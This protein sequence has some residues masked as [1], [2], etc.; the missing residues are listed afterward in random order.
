MKIRGFVVRL[1]PS[2]LE[3]LFAENILEVSIGRKFGALKEVKRCVSPSAGEE[4]SKGTWYY[5]T[6]Y[7]TMIPFRRF[8][9]PLQYVS[10]VAL[11]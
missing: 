9:L 2:L 8:H 5:N 11:L 6:K 10:V 4:K 1:T 3:T 7:E